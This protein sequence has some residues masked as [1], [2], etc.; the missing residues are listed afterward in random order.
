MPRSISNCGTVLLALAGFP[1]AVTA[2]AEPGLGEEARVGAALA[3]RSGVSWLS[4]EPFPMAALAG[5]LRL[6]TTFE[7]GGEGIFG[8][9]RV[10]LTP[11]GSPHRSEVGTGYGGV[12]LM[13]R[14]AG[15]APGIRW[16]GGLLLGAGAARIRSPL[17]G[18]PGITENYFVLEPRIQLGVAQDRRL[19]FH[20][21]AA[22][23][24]ALTADPPT[25]IGTAELRGATLSLAVQYVHD[26]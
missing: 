15:D 19:R 4:S 2:Q 21:E 24:I 17:A 7:V 18:T 10:R 26:P 20:G 22:Y 1:A 25:G 3:V 8:L 13:W 12:L 16:A 23:R 5:T 14:P 6:S 9:R 11:E